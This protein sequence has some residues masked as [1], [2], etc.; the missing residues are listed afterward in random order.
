MS[1]SSNLILISF[2]FLVLFTANV[3]GTTCYSYSGFAWPDQQLCPGS[4]A[5]CGIQDT[6]MPNR[7]CKSP[8]NR[9]NILVRGPCRSTPWDRSDC[10]QICA[11]NETTLNTGFADNVFPRVEICD[12]NTY[13]CREG[14]ASCCDSSIGKVYLDEN[15]ILLSEAP[16]KTSSTNIASSTEMTTS[17]TAS[18]SSTVFATTTSAPD[19]DPASTNLASEPTAADESNSGSNEALALKVGLGVG[20]PFAAIVAA[21]ATWLVYRK[22]RNKSSDASDPLATTTYPYYEGHTGY[23]KSSTYRTSP[24]TAY[25]SSS[26][27]GRNEMHEMPTRPDEG[28]DGNPRELMGSEVRDGQYR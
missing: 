1:G 9:D 6:C 18:S 7:L 19:Q 2:C 3:E 24:H 27:P 25:R 15:G 16:I 21:L 11:F 22:R 20:I 10:A 17:T 28:W 4:D 8:N 26:P 12:S 5:C 14:T 23:A 13:C